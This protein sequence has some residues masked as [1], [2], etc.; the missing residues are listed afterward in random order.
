M[1]LGIMQP[2]FI[3]YI[4]Y[5]QLLNAV[6]KYV[7]YDDVNYIKG[8]WINRNRL[9][10]NGEVKYYNVPLLGAS[11]NKLINQVEVNNDER[12]IEKNLRILYN[13]YKKAPFFER[14]FSIM[15]EI[16]RC[17]IDNIASYNYFAILKISE[18]LEI[19]TDI[20]LSSEIKKNN[21]LQ[22]QD[23]IIEI[24]KQLGATEYYNAIGGKNLYSK[25]VFKENNIKL[26]FLESKISCYNQ[27]G[28][29][30]KGGLSIIDVMM[31]NSKECIKKFLD[32]YR[33]I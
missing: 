17:N 32:D 25:T 24:C 29:E 15:E 7:V 1:K 22:G 21:H 12:L 19:D 14:T 28:R 16:I 9:L 10:I 6:D 23:K 33:L 30:F 18:Y 4:G 26:Y 31:F 27:F 11:P 3:P 5:W 13:S 20:L 8:G 2:Y